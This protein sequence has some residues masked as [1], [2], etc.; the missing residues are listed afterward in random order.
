MACGGNCSSCGDKCEKK[1][2]KENLHSG[3]SVKKV[4]GI[5]S[6]KG[7][8]GKSLVT[9][10]LACKVNKDG[11]RTAILDAVDDLALFPAIGGI[12]RNVPL[13]TCEY[14]FLP[15]RNYIVFYRLTDNNVFVDRIL[16]KKRDYARLLGLQ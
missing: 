15:V 10:L 12:V 3:S 4:I 13:L 14:R 2:L 7:G 1:P 8:V 16:Y 9:S 5:V 11:F 6:G